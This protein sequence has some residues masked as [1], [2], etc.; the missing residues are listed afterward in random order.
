MAGVSCEVSVAHGQAA[1]EILARA[2][3]ADLVLMARRG[4]SGIGRWLLGGVTT[5]VARACPTPVL[6]VPAS[7]VFLAP[8]GLSAT[9]AAGLPTVFLTA[10]Y[11]LHMLARPM[12]G[13]WVLVHSAAGGVG[14]ILG[15][16]ERRM[17]RF[18]ELARF[19]SAIT[20]RACPGRL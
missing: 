17:N 6:V 10:D 16:V 7:Q 1:S 20:A 12:P 15:P 19:G 9:Q 5:K 11:A 14:F 18:P 3:A 8:Q 13:E 4:G 2:E